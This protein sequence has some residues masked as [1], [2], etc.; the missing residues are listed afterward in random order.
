MIL[1]NESMHDFVNTTREQQFKQFLED[2][3]INR[4]KKS[5]DYDDDKFKDKKLP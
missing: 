3:E 4:R 2:F 1:Q 5:T